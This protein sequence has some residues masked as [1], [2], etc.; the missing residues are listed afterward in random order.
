MCFSDPPPRRVFCLREQ[1]FASKPGYML[2]VLPNFEL[3]PRHWAMFDIDRFW[4]VI[5][6]TPALTPVESIQEFIDTCL[7]PE[8][9]GVSFHWQLSS[10]AGMKDPGCLKAHIWFWL[11][12][13]YNGDQLEAWI[14]ANSLP[15]DVA[16]MRLVQVHYTANPIFQNGAVDPVPSRCGLFEGSRA[17]VPLTIP[18]D[19][20]SG[21]QIHEGNGEILDLVDPTQK[22][23]VIGAFCRAYH[24]YGQVKWD[25]DMRRIW[26]RPPWV[27][28]LRTTTH[29]FVGSTRHSALILIF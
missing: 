16:P 26:T 24:F 18:A 25:G 10:S 8:F 11:D 20:L 13:P 27:S 2:R 4:P 1:I 5:F 17:S 7:P 28:R 21:V 22:P 23:G 14:R 3:V 12:T 9:Q 15:I 19:V 29:G 6:D